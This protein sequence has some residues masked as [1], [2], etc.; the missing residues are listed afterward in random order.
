MHIRDVLIIVAQDRPKLL[1]QLRFLY[2][3][4]AAVEVRLDRRQ[5]QPWAGDGPDRRTPRHADT[6][7]HDHG[8]VVVHRS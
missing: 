3:R 2:A 5:G 6:D 7:L 4:A 1:A 8:F